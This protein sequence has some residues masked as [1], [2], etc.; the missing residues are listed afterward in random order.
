MSLRQH[1]DYK[2]AHELLH[3]NSSSSMADIKKSYYKEALKH[4]PDK[5]GNTPESNEKFKL[6]HEAYTVLSR[7][8][9]SMITFIKDMFNASTVAQVIS[10][11]SIDLLVKLLEFI[12]TYKEFIPHYVKLTEMIEE[13]INQNTIVLCLKPSLNDLFSQKI[14]IYK[15]NYFPLWHREIVRTTFDEK[16][17]VK[18][19]PELPTNMTLD[20]NNT[21]HVTVHD[22]VQNVFKNKGIVVDAFIFIH[23]DMIKIKP[24]QTCT[25]QRGIPRIDHHDILSEIVVYIHLNC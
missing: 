24:F 25:L 10:S 17:I 7:E 19:T 15:N 3:V 22:T 4:H 6:I 20:E 8:D 18:C 9:D 13:R 14:Y 21:L 1:M 23:P 12:Q 11:V 2:Q 5:N 16:I